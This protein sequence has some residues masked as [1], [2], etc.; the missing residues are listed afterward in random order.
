[1]GPMPEELFFHQLLA[2]E[3]FAFDDSFASTMRNHIYV[4]GDSVT[5]D[6]LLVDPAYDVRALLEW[7]R[8]AG[9]RLAGVLA[10][11]YHADHVGGDIFGEHIEGL[12]DLLELTAV[13]VH[14]QKD[15][16]PWVSEMTGAPV[17]SLVQH[18]DDDVV[19]VGSLGVRLLHTPGHT[20]GSQCLVVGDNL[21]TGDTLF[22]EGCGRTDL[23]GADPDAMYTSL[24]R[25]A[26]LPGRLTVWP[27]HHYSPARS[28]SLEQVRRSNVALARMSREEWLRRFS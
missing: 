22:I 20:P 6:V 13:P 7:V 25:L 5:G 8:K 9:L 28:A 23:P 19:Q 10:T 1:M 18:I 16:V 24:Q 21:V 26:S 4:V 12:V 27:G 2:G 14:V 3:D 17:S 15:E 11:H